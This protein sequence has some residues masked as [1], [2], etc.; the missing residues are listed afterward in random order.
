MADELDSRLEAS[1]RAA[2]HHEA[3]AIPLLIRAQ[4]IRRERRMRRGRRLAVP[5]SLLGAAAV[6]A[7]LIATGVLGRGDPTGVGASPS[8]SPSA[9]PRPLA[10][11]E[12][13]GRLI[14]VAPEYLL[15][16]EH[17]DA[18]PGG[19]PVSKAIG[20]V[21]GAGS[22][23]YAVH[24]LGGSIDL[25][26]AVDGKEIGTTRINCNVKAFKATLPLSLTGAAPE[27]GVALTVTSA[28]EVRWRIVISTIP[29]R[30]PV[31]IAPSP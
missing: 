27:G 31:E 9:T 18:D 12:D 23:Q 25:V 8:P 19:K 29:V 3:D 21:F 26:A 13:L 24:C 11:N 2:L 22:A 20:T 4:D 6:V 10:S 28:P 30:I 16:G 14:G 7:V 17:P 1:L 15:S 5:A